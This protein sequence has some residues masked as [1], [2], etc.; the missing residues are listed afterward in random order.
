MHFFVLTHNLA[1]AFGILEDQAL[2]SQPTT[3]RC[4]K[5]TPQQLLSPQSAHRQPPEGSLSKETTTTAQS[6][7]RPGT[8]TDSKEPSR[9]ESSKERTPGQKTESEQ[10]TPEDTA[11]VLTITGEPSEPLKRRTQSTI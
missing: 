8:S 7:T 10:D 1:H 6:S 5:A 9:G 11:E 2:I 4:V 3:I